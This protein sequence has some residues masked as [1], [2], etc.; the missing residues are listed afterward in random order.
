[1]NQWKNGKW[2]DAFKNSI[3]GF[4]NVLRNERNIKIEFVFAIIAII[5]GFLL[6]ISQIE[7]AII[8]IVIFIVFIA[9][10]L[11]TAVENTVDMMSME[12]NEKAKNAKDIASAA[13][14]ISAVLSI[15]IGVIIFLPK[16]IHLIK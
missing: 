12:Y 3:N 2:I 4:K 9:E 16:L 13:V 1:M 8:I 15:I 11:N 10:F 14:S 6:K 7:F 5:V